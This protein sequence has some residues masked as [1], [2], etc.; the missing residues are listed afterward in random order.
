MDITLSLSRYYI[1][2]DRYSSSH[3]HPDLHLARLVLVLEGGAEGGG[4]PQRV[5]RPLLGHGLVALVGGPAQV[6]QEPLHGLR[7]PAHSRN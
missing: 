1:K 7:G 3:F 2:R 5:A 6:T 4:E